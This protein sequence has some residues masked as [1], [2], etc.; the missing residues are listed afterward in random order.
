M[1]ISDELGVEKTVEL[2]AGTIRYRE[3]G[4]GPAVVFVHGLLVNGDLW[5]DVVPAVSRGYRCLAPDWPLGSHSVP[6]RAGADLSPPGV[7]SLI[8]E[9]LE[10]LDLT[11][12][13]LVANDTG[14]ALT[15]IL[16]T[17][18]PERIGRVVL[19]PSDSFE[20]FFPPPFS[21]LPRLLRVPGQTWLMS[22]VMQVK[23]L[24]PLLFGSVARRPVPPEI[25]DSYLRP[26]LNAGIRRDLRAFVVA[27]HRRHTLAAAS[28]LPEF[29]KPVLL[30]WAKEEKLFP[31]LGERLAAVLPN[32]R[33]VEV[34]DSYTFVPEDQPA[35]LAGLITE[36]IASSQGGPADPA[37]PAGPLPGDPG[38]P[39]DGGPHAVRGARLRGGL[40]G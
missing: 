1:A 3:R 15:Q 39:D 38:S 9:F 21:V 14:G 29:T 33:L 30:T 31:G 11:D 17:T 8:G 16:M 32:A 13:A 20:R 34:A 6:V 5:R 28:A 35:V 40:G 24:R 23:S 2:S 36:F 12:V 19:T 18:N 27:V 7:A 25:A 26:C 22:R 37:H 4:S 10:A